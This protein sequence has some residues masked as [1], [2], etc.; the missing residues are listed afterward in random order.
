MES[1]DA[2]VPA[3]LQEG[4]RGEQLAAHFLREKGWEIETTNF[5]T[6]YGEID[7]IA[8]RPLEGGAAMIAFVEVKSRS[9]GGKM[10]P[11]LAVTAEKRRRITRMARWYDCRHGEAN[12]GYRFDVIGIDT[13]R[14]PPEIR[15]FE[16]AFDASGKPY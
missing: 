4:R 7:I 5:E 6:K 15:H 2:D 8:R 12:T 13:G 9:S 11:E 3:H 10:S 1:S 16:A 14:T